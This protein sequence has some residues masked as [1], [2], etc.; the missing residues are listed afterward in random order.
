MDFKNSSRC[1]GGRNFSGKAVVAPQVSKK[2]E[3]D[4][5]SEAIVN[6]IPLIP[7]RNSNQGSFG[8]T[9][10]APATDISLHQVQKEAYSRAVVGQQG[11]TGVESE[12]RIISVVHGTRGKVFPASGRFPHPRSSWH[13]FNCNKQI[14]LSYNKF[15]VPYSS[16]LTCWTV[17][18]P[19]AE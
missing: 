7:N 2:P 15:M 4:R 3:P 11:L 6:T 12:E 9:E 17:E 16:P 5:V 14:E 10:N 1:V 8:K 13:E 18:C 19:S